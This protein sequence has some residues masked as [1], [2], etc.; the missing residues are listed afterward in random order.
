MKG[1]AARRLGLLAAALMAATGSSA[2]V[3]DV[4]ATES[5][6]RVLVYRAGTFARL[7]HNHVVS[8]AQFDGEVHYRPTAPQ[9]TNFRLRF[10]V[11]ALVVDDPQQRA[12]AGAA[13]SAALD[14]DAARAT[15]DNMLG[16]EVLDARRYPDVQVRSEAV[17]GEPPELRVRVSVQIRDV[18][19]ELEVPVRV[20]HA[21]DRLQ[22]A[23]SV[24]FAQSEF[25][26]EPLRIFLGAVSVQDEIEVE[27]DLS[28]VRRTRQ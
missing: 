9:Q 7:G 27:F 19:R 24:R 21:A 15:R 26:I 2:A 6:V 22:V 10:P 17:T 23:G 16:A 5:Q 18:R 13:F 4:V 11:Q 8:S 28:A 20:R 3:Y 12:A 14:Q 25:G 1:A